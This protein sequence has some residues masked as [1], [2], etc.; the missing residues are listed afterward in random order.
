MEKIIPKRI[1]IIGS[2]G[3]GKTTMAKRL[4]SHLQIPYYELDNVVRKRSKTGDVMRTEENRNAYLKE[5]IHR[6]SWIIEGVHNT[7]VSPSFENADVI[8]Y[9]DI[10]MS[11]RRR[12]IIFRY[13]KKKAGLEKANYKP[14]LKLLKN[15]YSYNTVYENKKKPKILGNLRPY[16]SKLIVLRSNVEITNYF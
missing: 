15:L 7:W 4:S 2:I 16:E 1:H 14:T 6:D 12:R 13:F 9:L 11:T 10:K 5:I 8:I 3:S